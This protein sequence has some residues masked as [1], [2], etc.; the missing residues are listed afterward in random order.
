MLLT[1]LFL[2]SQ[3]FSQEVSVFEDYGVGGRHQRKR[4]RVK[5]EPLQKTVNTFQSRSHQIAD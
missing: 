1:F 5:V 2:Q 3:E 4:I